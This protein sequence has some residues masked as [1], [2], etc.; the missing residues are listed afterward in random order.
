MQ[1][2]QQQ[3]QTEAAIL[4]RKWGGVVVVGRWL[5]ECMTPRER[6]NGKQRQ[7]R[8]GKTMEKKKEEVCCLSISIAVKKHDGQKQL[9]EDGV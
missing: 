3:W 8:K 2:R 7:L 6:A 1:R 9:G 4:A 5:R